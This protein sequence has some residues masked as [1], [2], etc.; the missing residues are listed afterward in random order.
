MQ[1][2]LTSPLPLDQDVSI[3]ELTYPPL[4]FSL[5]EIA[6]QNARLAKDYNK[7]LMKTPTPKAT[8]VSYKSLELKQKRYTARAA[9]YAKAVSKTKQLLV[10]DRPSTKPTP[11]VVKGC[12]KPRRAGAH[13]ST[14]AHNTRPTQ[15]SASSSGSSGSDCHRRRIFLPSPTDEAIRALKLAFPQASIIT[16]DDLTKLV[17]T[18][19]KLRGPAAT[20]AFFEQVIKGLSHYVVRLDGDLVQDVGVPGSVY[21]IS[22][23]DEFAGEI[24]SACAAE[25]REL[26]PNIKFLQIA[27]PGAALPLD[28]MGGMT[29]SEIGAFL[30]SFMPGPVVVR[31]LDLRLAP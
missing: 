1:L 23:P 24:L 22:A 26:N 27:N 11:L 14:W 9:A 17:A 28:K 31:P 10:S 15:A 19:M 25:F 2:V 3:V 29:P 6:E 12:A 8:R 7:A 16:R 18:S 4:G 30:K 13:R 5:T 21:E 20:C